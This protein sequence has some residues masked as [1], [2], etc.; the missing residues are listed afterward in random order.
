[1]IN[2][3]LGLL[4]VLGLP[5][6]IL[7]SVNNS[8]A[9]LLT[10]LS[11]SQNIFATAETYNAEAVKPSACDSIT[12]DNN[13]ITG[14]GTFSDIS[15]KNSLL[16]G[17]DAANSMSGLDGNDCVV[18]NDGNDTLAG[19]A[20]TDICLGGNGDDEFSDCETCYGDSGTDTDL[21]A[22]CTISS[23]VELP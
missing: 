15:G 7:M 2:R 11:T 4:I 20:D 19:G 16:I 6:L 14:N 21:T 9:A 1:M 17:T 5:L 22:T 10:I 3:L 13:I 18:A 8:S 23:S 12:L